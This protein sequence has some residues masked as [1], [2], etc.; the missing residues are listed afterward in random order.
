MEGG[1][2]VRKVV[3]DTGPI[4]HLHEA[5]ALQLLALVGELFVPEAVQA[6][7]NSLLPGW[8]H[9]KPDWIKVHPLSSPFRE[10]AMN[11]V[12]AQLLNV[13]EAEAISLARQLGADWLLTDDAAAR[14]LAQSLSLEVHGSLGVVLWAAAEGHISYLEGE[15]ILNRLTASS[16]WVSASVIL[17]AKEALRKICER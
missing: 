14:L 13:G 4:L 15:E 7:L 5:E 3:A 8:G 9:I 1:K 11:W 10:E 12:L 17:E 6:E 16:L 2:E